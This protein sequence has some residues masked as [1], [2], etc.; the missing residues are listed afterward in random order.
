MLPTVTFKFSPKK[1]LLPRKKYAPKR[2]KK[3]PRKKF[4]PKKKKFLGVLE[5]CN[6]SDGRSFGPRTKSCDGR[7]KFLGSIFF[8]WEHIFLELN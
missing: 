4:A 3:L 5:S 7:K 2:K 8:S 1:N 6:A